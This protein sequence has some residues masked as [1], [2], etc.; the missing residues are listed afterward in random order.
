MFKT[1]SQIY[2]SQLSF[3]SSFP[4]IF[5]EWLIGRKMREEMKESS[6]D[7]SLTSWNDPQAETEDKAE[8]LCNVGS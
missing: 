6:Q 5:Y 2:R 3:N 1:H 4:Y 8:D 7:C